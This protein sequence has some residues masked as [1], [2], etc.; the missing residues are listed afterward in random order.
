M[1][2]GTVPTLDLLAGVS[3]GAGLL[4]LGAA[5]AVRMRWRRQREYRLAD[6]KERAL[7]R[8]RRGG[9]APPP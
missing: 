6:P 7:L 9:S 8:K 2:T 4:S 5:L 1:I 3:M